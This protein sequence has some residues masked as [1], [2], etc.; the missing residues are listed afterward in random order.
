MTKEQFIEL[1]KV[2]ENTTVEYKTCESEV[3][4]SVYESVCSMLNHNGG[5]IL[6]GV[7][8]DGE[9]MG[10]D[11]TKAADMKKAI[12]DA[13]NNPELFLPCPFFIPEILP[14][15]GKTCIALNIPCGQYVYRY[16][17]SYWDR[18]GESDYDVTDSPEL[19]LAL[20]ERKNPHLFEDREVIGMNMADID[21][22]TLVACRK[23]VAVNHPAH[24][25]I[26][27]SDEEILASSRLISVDSNGKQ[28]FKFASLLLFGTD[29]AIE[30][31]VPRYRFE[32]IFR[33]CTF[34]Q[35]QKM[36]D[37]AN[38]YDDR[39]TLRCNLIKVYDRLTE[40]TLRHMPDK[41]YLPEGSMQRVDVRLALMREVIGNLC[42]HTDYSS[43]FACFLE[44]FKDRVMT[45]NA[46]RLIP[47]TPEGEISIRQLGNYTKNPLL[48]KVFH[49]LD[50]VEDLGSGTR[51][52]LKYAP[53]YYPDYRIGISNGQQFVFA[54]TYANA[55]DGNVG[56]N[57]E[58]SVENVG[59]NHEMSVENVGKKSKAAE[60]KNKRQQ[61]IVGLI[62]ANP[63]ITQAQMAEKLSVTTKTIERDS[64]ELT[65]LGIIRYEGDK[66]SGMWV[67]LK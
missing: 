49:E 22:E 62:H 19:L 6:M 2:G 7:S 16:K 65:S 39:V 8:D 38:R 17:G 55:E 45:R 46:T 67:L 64:D 53:L 20:F 11:P 29:A 51:N 44:I 36:D 61:A 34:G 52:I 13:I 42:V 35:Y 66:K 57:Q 47:Q 26:T 33:M 43:G 4:H 56:K 30:R 41:F 12:M 3:S 18:L 15:E 25:W 27:M 32:A 5:W 58:M 63:H 50:W 28:S 10:V 24:P 9:I 14:V 37:V 21:S 60:K 59:R 48:V 31:F 54:I 23:M 40:F 1:C